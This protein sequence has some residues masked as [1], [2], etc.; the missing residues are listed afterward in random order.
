[1]NGNLLS[2]L[3]VNQIGFF[4]LL[5]CLCNKQN[6]IHFQNIFHGI[7]HHRK[8]DIF[9]TCGEQVDIWDESRSEPI[10]SFSWG[11]DTL[12][13]IK[14]NPIEVELQPAFSCS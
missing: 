10:R 8:K 11:V 3:N 1:M 6:K 13:S 4:L 2:L 5:R 7:D 14:F 9:A 12:H